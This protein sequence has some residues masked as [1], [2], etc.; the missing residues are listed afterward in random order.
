MEP[1]IREL[2]DADREANHRLGAEAFGYAPDG[3]PSSLPPVGGAVLGAF[4]GDEL[5]AKIRARDDEIPLPGSRTLAMFG[6]EGVAVAPEARG[7]GLLS[8]LFRA[9]FDRARRVG[10]PISIL[11]PTAA[12][13]YRRFGYEVVGSL[14]QREIPMSALAK[15][16]APERI[17]LRRASAADLDAIRLLYAAWAAERLGPLTRIRPSAPILSADYLGSP[18]A[19]TLAIDQSGKLVGSVRWTRGTGYDPET[20][21]IEVEDLI[22]LTPDASR[23]MWRFLGTFDSVSSRVNVELPSG[24]E[25]LTALP[26]E[27]APPAKEHRYMLALLDIPAALAA[28]RGVPGLTAQLPFKVTGGFADG[29]DGQ[30][31][32][33]AASGELHCSRTDS[34]V[35]PTF[36]ARGIA[37]LYG[38]AQRCAGLRAGGMLNGPTDT[39][40]VWDSLFNV[41]THVRDY[42]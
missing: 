6:V 29:V 31:V 12:G 23:A 28:R 3:Q 10:Q 42:F 24:D 26:A 16:K 22:G 39:D 27:P 18:A 33:K 1:L 14:E 25:S 8:P 2:T 11:F 19:V 41:P 21:V 38:G 37:A 17:S 4:V 36:H 30:Y 9:G 35:G 13:I 7:R 34:G 20:S 32:L 5:T 40:P 15:I